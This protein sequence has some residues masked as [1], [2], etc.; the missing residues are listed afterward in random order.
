MK[1]FFL[2]LKLILIDI[3]LVI[4]FEESECCFE[5]EVGNSR[6]F[7]VDEEDTSAYHCESTC[8]YEK[9]SEAGSRYC[10]KTGREPFYC[11]NEHAPVQTRALTT[12]NATPALT[13]EKTTLEL[14]TTKTTPAST[15]E[16]STPAKKATTSMSTEKSSLFKTRP[17]VST[18]QTTQPKS[19]K[20]PSA[21][22]KK[23]LF[24]ATGADTSRISSVEVLTEGADGMYTPSGCSGIADFPVATSSA[25]GGILNGVPH[26]CVG[27]SADSHR[28]CFGFGGDGSWKNEFNLT[29]AL[30][31]WGS[32]VVF[33]D[34][35]EH[36]E[37]WWIIGGQ[38]NGD[39]TEVWGGFP[40]SE[41]SN[42]EIRLPK[43]INQPCIVKISDQEAF[44]T[45][46]PKLVPADTMLAWIYN[47][48]SNTWTE[49]PNTLQKRSG[50]SCGYIQ[51]DS[52]RFVV[53]AGGLSLSSTEILD[54]STLI[55]STGPDLGID[56]FGGS[57][58]SMYDDELIL[59]G[60]YSGGALDEIRRMDSS[61]S[62]WDVVGALSTP[63]FN[64]VALPV[65][66]E[67]L[68]PFCPSTAD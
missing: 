49:L 14:T 32:S 47:I 42:N 8:V 6:Y 50:P 57:M 37:A 44:V 33:K 66:M 63:R 55:W 28:E 3:S 35:D 62:S 16:K 27:F 9:D 54:L 53:L 18:G 29:N 65:P 46:K 36:E 64:A 52:G 38:P 30:W 58:V 39:E 34:W 25:T 61:M 15:T 12:E 17:E 40:P 60:G 10:F 24:I 4:G 21:I 51:T 1:S 26:V 48:Q 7:L 13:S 11:V 56:I 20:L 41:I 19:T 31:E 22:S 43:I 59:I 2:F 45:A 5:K 67:L 23:A 68:S